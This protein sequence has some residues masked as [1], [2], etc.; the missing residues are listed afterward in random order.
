VVSKLSFSSRDIFLQIKPSAEPEYIK[1]IK[2][3]LAPLFEV[4][5]EVER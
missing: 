2:G 5:V 1:Q 3:R 4:G